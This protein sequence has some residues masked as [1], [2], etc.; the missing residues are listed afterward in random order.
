MLWLKGASTIALTTSGRRI[1][2]ADPFGAVVRANP[3]QDRVLA[4]CRLGGDL[5]HPQDLAD[6]VR[7]FHRLS[8]ISRLLANEN[9]PQGHQESKEGG[10]VDFRVS[11]LWNRRNLR[12]VISNPHAI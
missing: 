12:I 6:H 5:S 3:H 11:N 8:D 9:S 7:D 4:A 2:L 1:G 10:S